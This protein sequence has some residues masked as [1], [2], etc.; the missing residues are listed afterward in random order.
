M[1]GDGNGEGKATFEDDLSVLGSRLWSEVARREVRCCD[2][3]LGDI[4]T[5]RTSHQISDCERRQFGLTFTR[6]DTRSDGFI[7]L[8]TRS[9]S[10]LRSVSSGRKL[11]HVAGGALRWLSSA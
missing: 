1:V 8:D 7:S 3:S 2:L 11:L 4:S 6:F 9:S 10:E 5:C